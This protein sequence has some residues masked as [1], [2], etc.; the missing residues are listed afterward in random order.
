MGTTILIKISIIIINK[1]GKIILSMLLQVILLLPS[2]IK[3]GE[4]NM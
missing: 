2:L 1:G 3:Q 4:W